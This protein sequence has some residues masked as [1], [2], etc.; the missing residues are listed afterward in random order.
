MPLI[1][2]H[3]VLA[4]R[5]GN[6]TDPGAGQTYGE[7]QKPGLN[8]LPPFPQHVNLDPAKPAVKPATYAEYVERLQAVCL[9]KSLPLD[10]VGTVWSGEYHRTSYPLYRVLV[11]RPSPNQ[12]PVAVVAGIHGNESG[13]PLGVLDFLENH[14]PAES[15][16]AVCPVYPL[17]NPW[18]FDHQKR[19]NGHGL[20][21]NRTFGPTDVQAEEAKVLLADISKFAV[22]FLYTM[23]EDPTN[24]GYYVYYSDSAKRWLAER[25]VECA[26]AH[27]L[28]IST[29]GTEYGGRVRI[30]RGLAPYNRGLY[31][32]PTDGLPLEDLFLERNANHICI[33]TPMQADLWTRTRCQ[34]ACLK[35][36]WAFA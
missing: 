17:V 22:P 31:P 26:K 1:S 6:P 16:G 5:P 35:L 7:Y 4:S 19:E 2:I 12:P 9:S 8:P 36:I 33:E 20:D 21:V 13:G 24:R 32:A 23:H 30:D 10:Y 18:G 14:Y 28:P 27:N 3:D 11:R 15:R 34:S 29:S 25:M